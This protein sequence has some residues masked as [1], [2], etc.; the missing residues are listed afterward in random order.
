MNQ[1]NALSNRVEYYG[2]RLSDDL[3]A[4]DDVCA[5]AGK[6]ISDRP[7]IRPSGDTTLRSARRSAA[8]RHKFE[9]F[10]TQDSR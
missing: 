5:K 1:L 8:L 4:G 9:G 10:M 6:A 3:S 7:A 2:L